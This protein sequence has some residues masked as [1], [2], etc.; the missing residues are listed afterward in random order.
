M[1]WQTQL[2]L[3]SR[4]RAGRFQGYRV[5]PPPARAAARLKTP[6]LLP[7]T[8]G[9]MLRTL[10]RLVLAWGQDLQPHEVTKHGDR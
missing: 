10:S 9:P 7:P 4:P 3:E 6:P 5:R 1:G 8:S 2:I